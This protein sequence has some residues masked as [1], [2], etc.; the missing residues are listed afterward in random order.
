MQHIHSLT[1]LAV[2]SKTNTPI[3]AVSV[4]ICDQSCHA[5]LMLYPPLISSAQDWQASK[6][7]LLISAAKCLRGGRITTTAGTQVEVDPNMIEAVSLRRWAQCE[8]CP[9]N[10]TFPEDMFDTE[11]VETSPLRLQFTLASLHSFIEAAPTQVYSGYLSVILAELHLVSLYKKRQI[12][13]ME[14]CG[15]PIYEN[16]LRGTCLQ[17][18][19]ER[20]LRI[21][22]NLVGELADETA[23]IYSSSAPNST[24]INLDGSQRSRKH[25]KVL[26]SDEAWTN[27]L[28]RTPE[29]FAEW[30]G[31]FGGG[32]GQLGLLQALEYRLSYMR[33]VTMIGWTGEYGGGRLAILKI[34]Q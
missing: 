11:A 27:L 21:N 18:G 1:S 33:V 32:P 9:I 14:C 2:T 6:T 23:A 19:T 4:G 26:W 12:F 31:W 28:G 29:E 15:M 22:P 10:E 34:V 13:S 5:T 17:C 7:V 25:S 16:A 30:L 24:G 3:T 8:N 20:Q